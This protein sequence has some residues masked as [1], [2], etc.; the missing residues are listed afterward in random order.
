MKQKRS[1][2]EKKSIKTNRIHRKSTG[3]LEARMKTKWQEIM[4]L[5]KKKHRE[6]NVNTSQFTR[7]ILGN[8]KQAND[9]QD[10]GLNKL[11]NNSDRQGKEQVRDEI[12]QT[13]THKERSQ[14]GQGTSRNSDIDKHVGWDIENLGKNKNNKDK[15]FSL[16]ANQFRENKNAENEEMSENND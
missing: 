16:G 12:K 5:K 4:I 7:T 3:L 1:W 2:T 11:F 9:E 14:D 15:A 10:L 6:K 8:T 13:D